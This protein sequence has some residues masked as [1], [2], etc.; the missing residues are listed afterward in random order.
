MTF[1]TFF[2]LILLKINTINSIFL[3]IF[4]NTIKCKEMNS[5]EWVNWLHFTKYPTI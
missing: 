5:Y 2:F 1:N 4:F 3:I